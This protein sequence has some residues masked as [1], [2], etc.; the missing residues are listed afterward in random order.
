MGGVSDFEDVGGDSVIHRIEIHIR[1]ETAA[2]AVALV[3]NV[4]VA[5][6]IIF[7][8]PTGLGNFD[9][10]VDLIEDVAPVFR[11]IFSLWEKGGNDNDSDAA[12][13]GD[14]FPMDDLNRG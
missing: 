6:V 13:A 7:D 10:A 1:Q 3:G 14:D 2:L 4:G 11:E 8:A 5:V 12:D 9:D